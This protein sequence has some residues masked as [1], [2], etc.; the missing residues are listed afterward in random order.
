MNTKNMQAVKEMLNYKTHKSIIIGV[1]YLHN[2]SLI[3]KPTTEW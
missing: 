3:G 1:Y 2:I